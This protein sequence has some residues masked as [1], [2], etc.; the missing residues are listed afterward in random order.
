MAIIDTV[1]EVYSVRPRGKFGKPNEIGNALV[2]DLE[3]GFF[4]PLVGVYDT[5]HTTKGIRTG[6]RLYVYPKDPQTEKQIWSRGYFTQIQKIFYQ[7]ENDKKE[8]CLKFR[9]KQI[10]APQSK[11][12]QMYQKEK[13]SY[14]GAVAVGYSELGDLTIFS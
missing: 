2:G 6:R 13:P 1:D 3:I 4:D 14:I 12:T 9:P 7:L 5:R 10:L 11:F 8:I